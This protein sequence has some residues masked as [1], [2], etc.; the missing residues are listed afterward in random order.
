M[1]NHS[2]NHSGN[3]SD[4][5]SDNRSDNHFSEPIIDKFTK[6]FTDAYH[7]LSGRGKTK[8]LRY[9]PVIFKRWYYSAIINE[10]TLSPSF[11]YN[12]GL[13]EAGCTFALS[14]YPIMSGNRLKGFQCFENKYSIKNHPVVS[15]MH[16]LLEHC[17]PDVELTEFDFIPAPLC[18]EIGA[19]LSLRDP[20]YIEYLTTVAF[21]LNLLKKSD[22]IYSNKA[23]V[24]NNYM[25][26]KALNQE[27]ALKKIVD[28]T[29][30]ICAKTLIEAIPQSASV[31]SP[32]GILT[33]IKTPMPIDEIFKKVY[34]SMGINIEQLWD[35][36]EPMEFDT[37]FDD[38]KNAI[39]SSTFFLGVLLDKWFITP[40]GQYLKI[41][42][43]I[44][45]FCYNFEDELQ[46]LFDVIQGNGNIYSALFS[47]CAFYS[48]TPFGKTFFAIE[49]DR[50]VKSADMPVEELLQLLRLDAVPAVRS[51]VPKKPQKIYS[52][53]VKLRSDKRLW[54]KINAAEYN[55]LH[56]LHI[57]IA[58]NFD[59]E[60]YDYCIYTDESLSPFCKY[61]SPK[62]RANAN[63]RADRITLEELDPEIGAKMIYYSGNGVILEIEFVSYAEMKKNV[64]Y[65]Q[66]IKQSKHMRERERF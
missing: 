25:L 30:Q 18:E 24:T 53:K 23:T 13:I 50:N 35:D 39:L 61:S 59:L 15:D 64:H 41:I 52:F 43:P 60:L 17:L 37:S 48:F 1:D 31:F 29:I 6:Y 5:R 45:F 44:Y 27:D 11:I 55:T 32:D 47:P 8:L 14:V 46:Y 38:D 22:A 20:F 51:Y 19:L 66:T 57:E 3:H 40:F 56:E 34:I 49:P 33:L 63:R 9:C 7:Q 26:F 2:D 10:T 16:V 62:S 54:K 28:S 65:P 42:E 58:L 12:A 21:D 4:N 36:Y